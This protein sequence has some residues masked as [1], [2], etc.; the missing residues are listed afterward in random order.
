MNLI[1][2]PGRLERFRDSNDWAATAIQPLAQWG[3]PDTRQAQLLRPGRP[4]ET[5]NILEVGRDQP[6]GR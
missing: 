2:L 4:S 1:H 5:V 3:R 6:Q